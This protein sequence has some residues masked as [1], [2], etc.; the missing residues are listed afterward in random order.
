MI[1][2]APYTCDLH[3]ATEAGNIVKPA[4]STIMPTSIFS[5]PK[6]LFSYDIDYELDNNS[7]RFIVL[8]VLLG[9]L[10]LFILL[11]AFLTF[12]ACKKKL[13]MSVESE[14]VSLSTMSQTTL[15]RSSLRDN[16]AQV[17]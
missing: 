5:R 16:H 12:Y 4:A 8:Y 7:I 1:F 3:M 17:L 11:S 13:N 14:S 9:L 2:L 6:L 15:E 10:I